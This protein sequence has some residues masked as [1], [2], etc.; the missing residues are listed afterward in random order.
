M[1][2]DYVL[3]L[4]GPQTFRRAVVLFAER[5]SRGSDEILGYSCSEGGALC[6]IQSTVA[7]EDNKRST[8]CDG[9]TLEKRYSFE[10]DEAQAL[11]HLSESMGQYA[12]VKQKERAAAQEQK[13][14]LIHVYDKYGMFASSDY[15]TRHITPDP[16]PP[17][18]CERAIAFICCGR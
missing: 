1:V 12:E 11:A 4:A 14:A 8:W 7:G 9:I 2:F 5:Y 13:P 15:E 10:A 3:S 17:T 16:Q 18:R 6:Y